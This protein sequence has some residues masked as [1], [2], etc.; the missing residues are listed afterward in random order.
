[1]KNVTAC[2]TGIGMTGQMLLPRLN[3]RTYCHRFLFIVIRIDLDDEVEDCPIITQLFTGI[4]IAQG[5][6]AH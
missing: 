5:R 3:A 2:S 1:M 6:M 4:S